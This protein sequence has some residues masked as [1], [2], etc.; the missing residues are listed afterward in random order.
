MKYVQIH[1]GRTTEERV[2]T[3]KNNLFMSLIYDRFLRTPNINFG[4]VSA[5]TIYLFIYYRMQEFQIRI[6]LCCISSTGKR[7]SVGGFA[8]GLAEIGSLV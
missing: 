6:L 1:H 4:F 8:H 5:A 3:L 2:N 7:L